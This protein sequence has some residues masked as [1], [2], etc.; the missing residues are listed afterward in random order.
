I[1][2][3]R[4][5]DLMCSSG[6]SLS[7]IDDAGVICFCGV[8]V[9]EESSRLV[10]LSARWPDSERYKDRE[11]RGTPGSDQLRLGDIAVTPTG[12]APP[13]GRR[14]LLERRVAHGD[15]WLSL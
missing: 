14:A 5:L 2:Q 12:T 8:L 10:W 7:I 13:L 9:Q 4:Y 3:G 15:R 6:L 11:L 1:T